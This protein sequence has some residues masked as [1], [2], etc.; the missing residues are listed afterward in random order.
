MTV[1]AL[2]VSAGASGLG[3]A[4]ALAARGRSV[5]LVALGPEV[6]PRLPLGTGLWL[7]PPA[8]LGGFLPF[9]VDRGLLAG[10]RVLRLP[11]AR[12]GL[13]RGLPAR[14]LA[15]ALAGWSRTRVQRGLAALV[16]G[17]QETRSARD[18]L[19]QRH[20]EPLYQRWYAAYVNRRFGPPEEVVCGVARAVFGAGPSGAWHAPSDPRAAA[21]DGPV[22][23]GVVV[24]V[25]RG[26]VQL[27]DRRLEGE[28]W[29]DVDPPTAAPWLDGLGESARLDAPRLRARDA[30][31]VHLRGRGELPFELHAVDADCPFFRVVATGRLPGAEDPDALAVH[32]ATEPGDRT[33]LG[34]RVRQAVAGLRGVVEVDAAG[35]R[36]RTLRAWHPVWATAE[37]TRYRNWLLGVEALGL[38]VAGR[39]GLHAAVDPGTQARWVDAVAHPA[40]PG[41]REDYRRLIEPPVL[42]EEGEVHL[43][44]WIRR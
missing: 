11:V 33:P 21:W 10:G 41:Q 13:L 14:Q 38:K 19:V 20:G 26:G 9:V 30:V 5:K 37:L 15:P 18:W 42:D 43:G 22:E 8:S 23:R 3:V 29:L 25:D 39:L 44:D 12:A 27:A 7:D 32:F 6:E 34:E 2:V 1:D 35:A 4:R 24:R 16:G 36:V 17:G 40:S 28:V 31:E